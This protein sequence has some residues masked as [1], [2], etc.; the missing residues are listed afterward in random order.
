MKPDRNRRKMLKMIPALAVAT[1]SGLQG[2]VKEVEDHRLASVVL[3]VFSGQES[4]RVVGT[5]YLENC[6]QEASFSK[7]MA[8]LKAD[9]DLSN[10]YRA[11]ASTS[12]LRRR[13][14]ARAAADYHNDDC[15]EIAGCYLPVTEL[16]LCAL[17]VIS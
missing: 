8:H 7:L 1:P 13:L 14:H 15:V 3:E 5:A 4:A 9:L 2:A 6:P 16:R 11:G 10:W 17:S 12:E